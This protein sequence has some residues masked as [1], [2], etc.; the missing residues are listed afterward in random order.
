MPVG[1]G[2]QV[3]H[4]V[5]RNAQTR[6]C[7]VFVELNTRQNDGL[8]VS[9]EW[10]RATGDTQVVV[11]DNRAAI[12]VAFGVPGAKAAH[13]RRNQSVVT[14]PCCPPTRFVVGSRNK[15]DDSAKRTRWSTYRY[16]TLQRLETESH[17]PQA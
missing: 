1:A 8:T 7:D 11:Y 14:V 4:L 12:E 16:R 15:T 2:E 3:L 5:K 17:V 10:D 9:L 13:R 6:R